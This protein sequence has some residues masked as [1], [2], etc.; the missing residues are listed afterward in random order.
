M[1]RKSTS[2]AASSSDDSSSE[3]VA[4]A[5][6]RLARRV[7]IRG[8]TQGVGFRPFVYRA[9]TGRGLCGWVY[10]GTGGV[11]L[12]VEGSADSLDAFLAELERSPRRRR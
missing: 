12:H 2:S 5:A 3:P 11:E 8:T 7:S 10:N 9:A 4:G 6:T 1:L